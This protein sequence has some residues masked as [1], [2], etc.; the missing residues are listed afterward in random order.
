MA[1]RDPKPG[2]GSFQQAADTDRTDPI[3]AGDPVPGALSPARTV[4]HREAL[5]DA[6]HARDKIDPVGAVDRQLYPLI[7]RLS[8]SLTEDHY[9]AE[10]EAGLT[11]L[12]ERV[13]AMLRSPA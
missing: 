9:A 11:V 1:L 3:D 13:A 12:F 4:A 8:A 6:T 10:F 5:D 7:H 2:D